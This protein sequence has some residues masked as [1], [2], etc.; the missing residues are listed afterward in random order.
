M[1]ESK[2]RY[3]ALKLIFDSG[4]AFDRENAITKAQVLASFIVGKSSA[5]TETAVKNVGSKR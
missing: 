5:S 3:L 1:D 2:A 4:S